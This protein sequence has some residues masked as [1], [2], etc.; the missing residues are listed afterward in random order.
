M[1][2]V[3]SKRLRRRLRQIDDGP[4]A[5]TP[6]EEERRR[7]RVPA[8]APEQP[9]VRA[10]DPALS[11]ERLGREV[12]RPLP[13][14]NPE[15]PASVSQV[16]GPREELVPGEAIECADGCYW[17]ARCAAR[18]MLASAPETLARFATLSTL[19]GGDASEPLRALRGLL[20]TQ[21]VLLDLETGGL[22][23]APIFLAGLIVWECDEPSE[24]VCVQLFARDYSE[25]RAVLAAAAELLRGRSALMTFNG[26]AFDLPL[27]RE[28]M[29]YHGLGAC[30]EPPEHLDLLHMARSRFRGRWEN[31]RLQTLERHLCGR[32]RVGDIPGAE[33]PDAWHQFVHSGDA[34]RMMAVMEH[35]RLDLITMLEV[36]PHL[37]GSSEDA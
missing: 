1:I 17:C 12:R 19:I 25:E 33:I 9:P 31:C 7:V 28:R 22:S 20:P 30:P 27:L 5:A 29:I 36:L 15:P 23:S 8:R 32:A 3:L 18:E 14:G 21:L 34:G 10:G 11:R 37:Q 6:P 24:A 35:N 13:Q 16:S 4:V 2:Q 26:R